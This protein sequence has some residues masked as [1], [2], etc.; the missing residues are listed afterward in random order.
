MRTNRDMTRLQFHQ[1]CQRHGFKP[2]GFMGYFD[3]GLP[4]RRCSVS[5][6]NAGGASRRARLAY[7]LRERD[8]GLDRLKAEQSSQRVSQTP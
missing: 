7:L 1:A 6:L 5:V 4:G 8:R 3:L 2:S